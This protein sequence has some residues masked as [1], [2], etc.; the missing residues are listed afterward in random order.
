[1]QAKV[2][3]REATMQAALRE[4]QRMQSQI[5]V[6]RPCHFCGF[7]RFAGPL[8]SYLLTNLHSIT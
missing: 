5:Q 8:V 4:V 3:E 7:D 6:L 1:M 2:Q